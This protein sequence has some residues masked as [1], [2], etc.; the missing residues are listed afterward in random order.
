MRID[1]WRVDGFGCLKDQA[2]DG[3][4]PGMT[5]ILG[6][7]EA[8]K[9]TLLAFLRAILFGFPKKSTKERQYPPARGGSHGGEVVLRD[10]EDAVWTLERYADAK[11]AIS[12]RAADGR[13]GGEDELRRLLGGIDAPLY[14]SVFAFSLT[15]LQDFATLDESG[16]RDR[17]FTSGISGAG[18][19]ARDVIKRLDQRAAA[20]SKHG[21]GDA[22]INNLVR[23]INEKQQELTEAERL[24]GRYSDLLTQEE[25][26]D[27]EA[28][29]LSEQA[30]PLRSRMARLEALLELHPH[31]QALEDLRAEL[32]RLPEVT[33]DTLPDR[34]AALTESL[35]QQRTREERVAGLQ[36][37]QERARVDLDRHLALLG[38]GWDV[39]RVR[40]FDDSVVV[41]DEVK[42]WSNKFSGALTA[43]ETAER[44]LVAL[45]DRLAELETNRER[46]AADL[47]KDEP[48]TLDA[49]VDAEARLSGLWSDVRDLEQQR[50]V[51]FT[52]RPA[53][54]TGRK[55]GVLAAVLAAT[56]AVVGAVGLVAGYAQLAVGL[57]IAAAM[58]AVTAVVALVGGD[59]GAS[60]EHG[61]SDG[62]RSVQA[63]SHGSPVD[64][65]QERVKATAE[66]LGLPTTPSSADLEALRAWLG[67]E[68]TRRSTWD[69][70]GKRIRDAD[71]GLAG[72]GRKVEAATTEANRLR[73]D[74][75]DATAEWRKWLVEHGL[76]DISPGGAVELL[77]TLVEARKADGALASAEADLDKIERCAVEWDEA[78]EQALIVA[79]RA[80][81]GLDRLTRRTALGTLHR[82]LLRR[83]EA[84]V[85]ID[86]LERTVANRFGS[87]ESAAEAVREL[88][89]GDDLDWNEERGH[90]EEEVEELDARRVTAI[91]SRTLARQQ[92]EAIEESADIA[93]LQ[94]ERESLKAELAAKV[95][96]YRVIVTARGLIAA[97][98]QAY[99]RERQPAVLKRASQSF[100]QVTG[101]RYTS[102][103]QD[104]EGKESVVVVAQDRRLAPE[105]LSRGT[106][107]QLYIAI[108]LALVGEVA[109]RSAPLPLIMDDCLVNFD[110]QR[111]EQMAR[112]LVSSSREGQCLL[113]TCHPET[114][115]LMVAQSEGA[116][117]V[118]ELPSAV[119]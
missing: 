106:A 80:V 14:K 40:A 5:V 64:D 26:H 10:G 91:E 19:S 48:W 78:A 18:Q 41:R 89:T 116:A 32:A 51:E 31:W 46:I 109:K 99:V 81:D 33:D 82:E 38:D 56:C 113:F 2:T 6:E 73:S 28:R 25:S 119:G 75:E 34:V 108:R 110:P 30:G 61:A 79:V 74:A 49:I 70:V 23:A 71:L 43:G 100:A 67:E 59:R 105:Q 68:R 45:R 12:L 60:R 62:F 52:Q 50:L 94:M 42:A 118:I 85:E 24:A 115:E 54:P 39:E 72:E 86:R 88:A 36:A 20:L 92:R 96:D 53:T 83:G 101:G 21:K 3:L 107:E 7:N 37:D 111:A 15:E 112:L 103:E 58:L 69:A 29:K 66:D 98:L 102:V 47:P 63:Q 16:V 104:E 95:H 77:G 4:E 22:E 87:A 13:Q 117:R 97:T 17:I 55:V 44:D 84:V 35:T 27:R 65:L 93:R 114:A 8:G 76:P 57:L 9:S 11:G 90:L 1:G